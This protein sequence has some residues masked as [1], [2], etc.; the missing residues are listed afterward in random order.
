VYSGYIVTTDHHGAPAEPD[1]DTELFVDFVNTLELEDGEPDD[2]VPDGSALR[3]W[4][5]EH[6]L[7]GSGLPVRKLDAALPAFRRLR[8]LLTE[9]TGVVAAGRQ[10]TATQVRAINDV[11]R[12]GAHFHE[13]QPG[14]A[15]ATYR[16]GHVG[17][18]LAQAR[19][20]IAGSLAHYLADH[21]VD[22]LRVCANDGCR[23]RF[24]DR[25][26]AGRR[27]WC[28]MRTCGNRAK[29]ARHRARARGAAA[30]G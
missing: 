25:S 2:H 27:R 18:E 24:I 10:P 21:P 8:E 7:C 17:D 20:T 19:A 26:P 5:A 14:A 9:V 13:L 23:W 15:G 1:R 16:M 29:V 30:S 12:E 4:L 3:A 11:L 22:R 6:E 28:D